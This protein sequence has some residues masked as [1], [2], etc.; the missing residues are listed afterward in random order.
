MNLI[1]IKWSVHAAWSLFLARNLT[2]CLSVGMW[3]DTCRKASLI[4]SHLLNFKIFKFNLGQ[5]KCMINTVPWIKRYKLLLTLKKRSCRAG[6]FLQQ[7]ISTRIQQPHYLHHVAA[8]QK[9]LSH[10]KCS[11]LTVKRKEDLSACMPVL[12]KLLHKL[13]VTPDPQVLHR[14]APSTRSEGNPPPCSDG[15]HRARRRTPCR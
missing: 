11:K 8:A 4:H 5:K 15:F 7:W 9:N 3:S 1:Q 14:W 13:Y 6:N 2:I 10:H 12:P